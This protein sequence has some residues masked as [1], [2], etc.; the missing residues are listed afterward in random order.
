MVPNDSLTSST[1]DTLIPSSHAPS[2]ALSPF[3]SP[4]LQSFLPGFES[5]IENM[6]S[7]NLP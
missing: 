1:P 7:A 6:E 2:R 3:P 5:V 4:E